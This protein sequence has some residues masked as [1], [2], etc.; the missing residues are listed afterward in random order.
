MRQFSPPRALI[1]LYNFSPTSLPKDTVL[2]IINEC[3]VKPR[4][5]PCNYAFLCPSLKIDTCKHQ[6]SMPQDHQ[7]CVNVTKQTQKETLSDG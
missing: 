2:M 7:I 4:E 6:S 1:T 5:P 3:L